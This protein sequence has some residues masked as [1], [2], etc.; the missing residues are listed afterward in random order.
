MWVWKMANYV[1]LLL[2]ITAT[3]TSSK[4]ITSISSNKHPGDDS[5]T[6]D[7]SRILT[8]PLLTHHALKRRRMLE[9]GLDKYSM[10]SYLDS[11]DP[12]P[13]DRSFYQHRRTSLEVGGL[14]QGYGTHYVDLWVGTPAQRQTVIVD[15]GSSVTAFPCS[16]C[17]DCGDR[18]HASPYFEENN[19]SSFIKL[20]CSSCQD[21]ST[22]SHKD[23]DDE[24]CRIGVSYQEGSSWSAFYS[25]DEIYLGGPH[26]QPL[27]TESFDSG[28]GK[29]LGSGVVDENPFD[30]ASFRFPLRFGCQTKITGL[31]KTQLV[32]SQLILDC[33]VRTLIRH[34]SLLIQA[35]IMHPQLT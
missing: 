28:N 7:Q 2:S 19:S 22:C 20:R 14:Y 9:M 11:L 16:A 27:D 8:L 24:H 29:H 33:S 35:Y 26:D 5:S 10:E 4:T 1:L 32:S 21:S 25:E 13:H 6:S 18:Y 12:M 23:R 34:Y 30:A 17:T 31:F 15:T 3:C